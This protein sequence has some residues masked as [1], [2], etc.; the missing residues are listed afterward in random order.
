MQIILSPSMNG[1]DKD[2]AQTAKI[3]GELLKLNAEVKDRLDGYYREFFKG[4]IDL[5]N[6]AKKLDFRATKPEDIA[7]ISRDF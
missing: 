7:K 3:K 6:A 4:D 1:K 5:Q 2:V